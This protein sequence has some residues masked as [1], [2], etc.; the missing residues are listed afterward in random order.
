MLG[1]RIRLLRE[2]RGITLSGLAKALG[3]NRYWMREVE[4]DLRLPKGPDLIRL[5]AG[6]NVTLSDLTDS[7]RLDVPVE[8]S[9]RLRP[10][11]SQ[12]C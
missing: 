2:E 5:T 6:L 12:L 9:W 11:E 1:K 4:G 3:K 7:F 10:E 8:F